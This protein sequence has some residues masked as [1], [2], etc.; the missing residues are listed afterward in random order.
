MTIRQSIRSFISASFGSTHSNQGHIPLTE[1]LIE[2][3]SLLPYNGWVERYIKILLTATICEWEPY[4][5]NEKIEDPEVAKII[6]HIKPENLSQNKFRERALRR[7]ILGVYAMGKVNPS[8]P[9][10]TLPYYEIYHPT[11][12]QKDKNTG[13]FLIE[14][15]QNQ[16]K[17]DKTIIPEHAM[18]WYLNPHPKHQDTPYSELEPLLQSMRRYAKVDKAVCSG[19]DR[20]AA[21]PGLIHIKPKDKPESAEEENQIKDLIQDLKASF[22][23][24]L[25]KGD[26]ARVAPMPAVSTADI[27]FVKFTEALN[28]ETLASP[29][30]VMRQAAIELDIP[31]DYFLEEG[32]ANHWNTAEQRRSVNSRNLQPLLEIQDSFFTEEAFRPMIATLPNYGDP[33][34]WH[35]KSNLHKLDIRVDNPMQR[36]ELLKAGAATVEEVAESAGTTPVQRPE[37]MTDFQYFCLINNLTHS[38]TDTKKLGEDTDVDTPEESNSAAVTIRELLQ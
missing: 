18:S 3:E 26:L 2:F 12:V 29:E 4:Y 38:N 21:T 5:K 7:Q 14:T 34:D 33:E 37:E 11:V 13:D 27:N 16:N 17:N 23:R 6:K 9:N 20:Q 35:L 8:N 22:K 30:I 10:D 15:K 36:V 24:A 28:P 31:T 32:S 25:S 1:S 19:L